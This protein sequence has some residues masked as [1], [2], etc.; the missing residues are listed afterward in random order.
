VAALNALQA[1]YVCLHTFKRI[2]DGV[3]GDGEI[4]FGGDYGNKSKT[5]RY[6]FMRDSP[7]FDIMNAGIA[8]ELNDA[9]L[10]VNREFAEL[11]I[12]PN[13]YVPDSER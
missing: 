8:K 2:F 13:P 9:L 11:G 10:R 5:G 3:S 7:G 6:I 4:H 1:R 12:E